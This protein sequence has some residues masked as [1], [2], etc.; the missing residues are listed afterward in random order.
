MIISYFKRKPMFLYIFTALMIGLFIA[1]V[2]KYTAILGLIVL[3]I[4]VLPPV[5]YV[6]YCLKKKSL[7][8]IF[9]PLFLYPIIYF[10]IFALGPFL[11]SYPDKDILYKSQLGV[12]LGSFGYSVGF[13]F[14]HIYLKE[15]NLSF[16]SNITFNSL[17]SKRFEITIFII[18]I[19]G[20]VLYIFKMGSIPIFLNDLE[21]SRVE[22]SESGGA[23]FRVLAYFLIISSTIGALNLFYNMN[24]L[25]E[26]QN[27]GILIRIVISIILL[28]TLGNRSPIY[29]I[30]FLGSMLFI[31][32]KF[33]GYFTIRRLITVALI[34][35]VIVITFVGGLGA[36]RVINTEAFHNYPEFKG[37]L[38]SGNYIGLS[39]YSFFHY[40]G[41]GYDNFTKTLLVFPELI[42]YK[43]GL[44]YIEPLLTILPGTQ[45]TLDMQIKM[46]LGQTY[47]GGGT[48]PTILGE[49]YANF[50][51]FGWFF[52]PFLSMVFMQL[53][54]RDLKNEAKNPVKI[55][56]YVFIYSHFVNS[57]LSGIASTSVFPFVT[58]FIYICYWFYISE[59]YKKEN[60]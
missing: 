48:I 38:Q 41:V 7:I 46:A 1:S 51:F 35:S 20:Y 37:Y 10:L 24:R 49:A 44:S 14:F 54:Y 59:R 33:N 42:N 27:I 50:G 52:I 28:F 36:Y 53:L 9:N 23:Y 2:F 16:G 60:M 11:N 17:N 30:M 12:I 43:F 3:I 31:Y 22:A 45:Y 40:L 58:I 13:Y 29:S 47:L 4:S 21:G 56:F 5:G 15:K 32:F 8:N 39:L 26:R 19:L 18:G 55:L 25:F 34:G 6:I 57:L